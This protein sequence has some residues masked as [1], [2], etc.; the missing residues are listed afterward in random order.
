MLRQ[1]IAAARHG[2]NPG[3]QPLALPEI[4]FM[5]EAEGITLEAAREMGDGDFQ[6]PLE[7]NHDG[8]YWRKPQEYQKGFSVCLI[9]SAT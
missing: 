8:S 2:G 7:L 3:G 4:L 5:Q 9:I 6:Q 1:R